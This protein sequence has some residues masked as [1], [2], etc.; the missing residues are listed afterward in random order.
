MCEY[1][2]NALSNLA[3]AAKASSDDSAIGDVNESSDSLFAANENTMLAVHGSKGYDNILNFGEFGENFVTDTAYELPFA[4]FD[5]MKMPLNPFFSEPADQ[6]TDMMQRSISPM[7]LHWKAPKVMFQRST[8]SA[9]AQMAAIMLGQIICSFPSMM[10]QRET[11]PPFIHTKFY[12]CASD[13][14]TMPN[15]LKD[16]MGLAQM[17]VSR[18]KES[19]GVFWRAVRMEQEKLLSQVSTIVYPSNI[20]LMA[21]VRILQ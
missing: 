21:A 9:E 6:M 1:G 20:S 4:N 12:S 16:C 11:F 19:S 13:S 5:A 10:T 7:S 17:F 3:E 18:T 2:L 15:I 8:Q 14:E